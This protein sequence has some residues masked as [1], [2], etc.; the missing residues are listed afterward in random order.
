M[1]QHDRRA[2]ARDLAEGA[3]EAGEVALRSAREYHYY[4]HGRAYRG[5]R[6]FAEA[7][8]RERLSSLPC[9]FGGHFALHIDLLEQARE[10]CWFTFKTF[11]YRGKT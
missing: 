8:V 10:A 7:E 5:G 11:E 9:V 1:S 6:A 2:P 4:M 3:F